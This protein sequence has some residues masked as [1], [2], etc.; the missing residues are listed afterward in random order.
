[1]KRWL[2]TVAIL[3]L[4]LPATR[5]HAQGEVGRITGTVTSIDG[6]QP[7]SG[8]RVTVLGT[9]LTAETNTQ[10]RYSISIAPGTYRL[11]TSAIGYTP[12]LMDSVPV[13]AGG[14]S[15]ANFQLKH[16]TV[17]LEKV[18]VT[19]YG[20]QAKR[21]VTGAIGQVSAEQIQQQPVTNVIEAIKGRAPGP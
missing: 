20:S 5:A 17:E 6:A 10:G 3:A 13:T 19:G 1:M 4:L 18:V 8:V 16:Q 12:V 7:L 9:R 14:T 11:R 21:D 2:T 15:T